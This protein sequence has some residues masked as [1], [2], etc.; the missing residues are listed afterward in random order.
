MNR[1]YEYDFLIENEL[2]LLRDQLNEYAEDGW[3]LVNFVFV[4]R[5]MPEGG[6]YEAFIERALQAAEEKGAY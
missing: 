2:H 5:N 6:Q 4:P 3:R 1:Q